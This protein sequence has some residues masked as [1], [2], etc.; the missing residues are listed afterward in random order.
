MKP[1]PG[2]NL[3]V[4]QISAYGS[5]QVSGI[6][7]VIAVI[8]SELTDSGIEFTLLSPG[9]VKPDETRN[10]LPFR[11]RMD[12]GRNLELALRTFFALIGRRRQ[13]DLVHAHQPHVQSI[14][15]L[16]AARI[17]GIPG[18]ITFHV[19]APENGI[20]GRLVVQFL[21]RAASSLAGAAVAVSTR[22]AMDF[23]IADY[24][25]VPNG[26]EASAPAQGD[27]RGTFAIVFVGRVT[28][29]KGAYVLLEALEKASRTIP[30]LRLVMYGPV[31]DAGH[32]DRVKSSLGVAGL[33]DDRGFDPDWRSRLLEGQIFVLPSYYEGLPIALLEAMASGLPPIVTPVGGIP[34]VV[35]HKETGL[36]VPV[37]DSAALADAIVWMESHPSDARRMGDAARKR[38][39]SQFSSSG[40][41]RG[42]ERIYRSLA[43]NG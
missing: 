28:Q 31:D 40:M 20:G 25:V 14:A 22:I 17:L 18:I 24:T 3:R 42:Y 13:F 11:V 37:G 30:A 27:A 32:Y 16:L 41:A 8:G 19:R 23:G 21:T 34:D 36:I 38:V 35:T 9:G 15:A 43:G 10:A 2:P 12:A 33:V 26:V 1:A 6:N 29:T 4:A 5:D 39:A 7:K